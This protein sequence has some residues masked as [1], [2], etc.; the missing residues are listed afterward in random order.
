MSKFQFRKRKSIAKGISLNIS[1]KGIGVSAGPKGMRVSRSATGRVSGSIG[2]PGSGLSYRKQLNSVSDD[3]SQGTSQETFMANLLDKQSYIAAH[4]PVFT[5]Q[6]LRK[7]LLLL[8]AFFS[9]GVAWPLLAMLTPLSLFINPLFVAFVVLG[10]LYYR[11]SSKNQRIY[12]E[13][14]NTHLATCKCDDNGEESKN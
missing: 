10:I 2:I 9:S 11:E 12:I 8:A 1:K 4:G 7:S 6:E 3:F 14:V 13:R 5:G